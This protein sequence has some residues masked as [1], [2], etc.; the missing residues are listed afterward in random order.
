[1]KLRK[2]IRRSGR[3]FLTQ[4]AARRSTR[5]TGAWKRALSTYTFDKRRLGETLRDYLVRHKAHPKLT[6]PDERLGMTEAEAK[7]QGLYLP[8][9][10]PV[11]REG[12]GVGF[13]TH[14]TEPRCYLMGPDPLAD[15]VL[16]EDDIR[17]KK[18]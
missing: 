17:L 4:M 7:D 11:Y 14:G 1:M 16:D 3:R 9:D 6:P 13:A 10:H 2:P 15:V 5:P 18:Q 12:F 8:E